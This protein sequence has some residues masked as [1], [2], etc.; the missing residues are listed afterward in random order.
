[1][2]RSNPLA[3]AALSFGVLALH[4]C[5]KKE[6]PSGG[7]TPAPT[8]AP[9]PA[10]NAGTTG[11]ATGA[12]ATQPGGAAPAGPRGTIAGRVKS[13]GKPPEMK[14]ITPKPTDQACLKPTPP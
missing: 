10:P 4:G 13:T 1:M 9:T 3:I 7:G 5:P 11:G 2:P 14:E 6:E 12:A 8:V